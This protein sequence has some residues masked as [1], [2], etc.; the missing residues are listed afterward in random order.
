[1]QVF[2][3]KAAMRLPKQT[4][5]SPALLLR[6]ELLDYLSRRLRKNYKNKTPQML[7]WCRQ[8]HNQSQTNH[9]RQTRQ[10]SFLS[11]QTK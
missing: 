5:L 2:L 11:L 8:Q 3:L 7:R 4:Q 6:W 10:P 9:R 1:M